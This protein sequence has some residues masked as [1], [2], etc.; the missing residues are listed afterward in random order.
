MGRGKNV[1]VG[2]QP[3]AVQDNRRFGRLERTAL[4]L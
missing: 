3:D 1:Y 4:C 2:R